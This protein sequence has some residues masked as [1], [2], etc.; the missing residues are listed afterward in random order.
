ML[1]A[2]CQRGRSYQSKSRGHPVL[3][4]RNLVRKLNNRLYWDT[5]AVQAVLGMGPRE[6]T[7]LVSTLEASGLAKIRRGTGPKTWTTTP[8]AQSF[9]SVSAAKP[10]TRK[11][12][13]TALARLLE[14][15]ERVNRDNH[16]LAKVTRVIVFGSYL[17]GDV[18]RLGDVDVAVELEPKVNH[19]LRLREL[20]YRRVAESESKGHRFSGMLDREMWWQLETFRFLKSRSR[21]ISL[22]D[23]GTKR[24]L[25]DEVPHRILMS[26][27]AK[28]G[29]RLAKE[30]P[31]LVRKAR[32]PRDCP[33]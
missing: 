1:D 31:K 16:F 2:V 18:N 7:G 5:K 8:L 29:Q 25:V 19:R 4:V 21:S 32:R 10:I 6:A 17:R 12:A 9:G 3:Q 15:I 33:F 27:R 26:P 28:S 20:N 22:H 30:S 23:Y 14:R 11:T 24:Q 13:E